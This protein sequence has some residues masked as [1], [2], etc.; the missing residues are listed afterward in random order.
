MDPADLRL[1]IDVGTTNTDAVLM[2]GRGRLVAK[3]KVPSTPVPEDGVAAAV[4]RVVARA[5]GRPGR[6]AAA[7]LGTRRLTRAIAERRGLARV[8]ALRV[9]A[10]LTHAAPPLATWPAD[11]RA[12]VSAGTAVVRGGA[13][14]DGRPAVALDADAIARFAI[15]VGG[16]ADGVAITSVFSPVAPEHELAAAAIVRRELGDAVDV[17]L[18]HEIGSFGLRERENATVLNAALVGAVADLG[19]AVGDTLT[20][21][22]LDA[23]PFLAQSD[24]TIMA[25]DHALGFPVLLIGAGPANGLRG[26][27]YLS[28]VVEGVVADVG[29][30]AADVGVLVNG[31]PRESDRPTTVAGVRTRVRMPDLRSIPVGGGSVV[32]LDRDPPRIGPDTVGALLTRRARV[33]GGPVLTVTDAV[34]AAGRAGIGSRALEPDERAALAPLV[35][36]IDDAL[37]DAVDR[38][39]AGLAPPIVVAVGGAGALVPDALAGAGEVIHPI[40]GAVAGAVGVATAPV[41]GLV[42]RI[43]AGADDRATVLERA[44]ADA[45]ARAVHAG[46]DPS[47]VEIVALE[48]IPLAYLLDTAVRIRVRAAGPPLADRP[49]PDVA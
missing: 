5:D 12:A 39:G 20:G 16:H 15:S 36:M 41:S 31:L 17:S 44:R 18:S 14:F 10:P 26:A 3:A 49:G 23:E 4:R 35:A 9:G 30:A 29:G 33:F 48:E 28:G 8:A 6:V 45:F 37:A 25:L 1:G 19:R 24:G 46:A 22:G 32:H 43:C 27:A 40:D 34:V 7:M 38:V 11:L 2:D 21:L 42:D 13:D 47:A